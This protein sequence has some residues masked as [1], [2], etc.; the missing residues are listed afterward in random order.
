VLCAVCGIRTRPLGSSA[1]FAEF[2]RGRFQLKT[3]IVFNFNKN[4]EGFGLAHFFV[5]FF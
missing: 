1:H 4:N 2:T 3:V 5:V